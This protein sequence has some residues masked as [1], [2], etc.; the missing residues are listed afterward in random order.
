MDTGQTVRQPFAAEGAGARRS[1]T[2]LLR[3]RSPAYSS[4]VRP[5]HH[6]HAVAVGSVGMWLL[7]LL[8]CAT[9]VSIRMLRIACMVVAQATVAGAQPPTS[10]PE[11][12]DGLC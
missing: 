10:R 11:T 1:T 7:G 3:R 9:A 8:R 6:R 5:R 4:D 12:T 2:A